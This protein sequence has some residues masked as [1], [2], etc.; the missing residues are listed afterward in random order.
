MHKYLVVGLVG[1]ILVVVFL[2]VLYRVSYTVHGGLN[3]NPQPVSKICDGFTYVM[4]NPKAHHVDGAV[5][6]IC[7]GNIIDRPELSVEQRNKIDGA[8]FFYLNL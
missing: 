1:I 5:K 2:F 3:P 6:G 8:R 7:L 4:G